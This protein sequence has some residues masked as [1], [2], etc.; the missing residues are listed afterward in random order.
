M[1]PPPV[2]EVC[3]KPTAHIHCPASATYYCHCR[4]TVVSQIQQNL[5]VLN[6]AKLSPLRI[7]SPGGLH[8]LPCGH[9]LALL[10]QKVLIVLRE[11]RLE[12]IAAGQQTARTSM[13]QQHNTTR[14]KHDCQPTAQALHARGNAPASAGWMLFMDAAT[15]AMLRLVT[16]ST[17]SCILPAD[18]ARDQCQL[19]MLAICYH[20][21]CRCLLTPVHGRSCQRQAGGGFCA[22]A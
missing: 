4:P 5:C 11:Q 22:A 13:R 10:L 17:P 16:C 19:S 12:D 21:G 9:R 2:T 18:D 14:H 15:A 8:A 7:A 1:L 6:P 3:C 20:C